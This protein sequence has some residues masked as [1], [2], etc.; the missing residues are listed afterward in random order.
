MHVAKQLSELELDGNLQQ[1]EQDNKDS[2]NEQDDDKEE[3][4]EE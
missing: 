4:E 3:D 2:D 1:R